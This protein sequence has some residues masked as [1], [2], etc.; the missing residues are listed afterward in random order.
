MLEAPYIKELIKDEMGIIVE[1][2]K[3]NTN[4][5][6]GVYYYLPRYSNLKK[7]CFPTPI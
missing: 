1:L 6:L 5:N 3:V 2:L 7:S 4:K